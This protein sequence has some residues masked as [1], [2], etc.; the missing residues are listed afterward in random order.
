MASPIG[1]FATENRALPRKIFVDL[2]ESPLFA[3]WSELCVD[4]AILVLS[5]FVPVRKQVS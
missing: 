1:P 4:R 3:F 5:F 2:V